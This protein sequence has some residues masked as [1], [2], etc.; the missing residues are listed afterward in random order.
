MPHMDLPGMQHPSSPYSPHPH[1]A[2][3]IAFAHL[4]HPPPSPIVTHAH[5]PPSPIIHGSHT[6]TPPSPDRYSPES[7]A[8]R[9]LCTA[10]TKMQGTMKDLAER[11]ERIFDR[12]SLLE[13][14]VGRTD[15]SIERILENTEIAMEDSKSIRSRVED[16]ER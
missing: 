7:K 3:N 9:Q 4:G 5:L 14:R 1:Y 12:M 15:E 6:Q 2:T 10:L 13:Q 8:L 16:G 11:Q